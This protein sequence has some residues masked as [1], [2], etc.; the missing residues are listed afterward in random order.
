M[1]V[2]IRIYLQYPSAETTDFLNVVGGIIFRNVK[3]EGII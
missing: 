1:D 2:V 3:W